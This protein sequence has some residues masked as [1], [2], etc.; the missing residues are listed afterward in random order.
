MSEENAVQKSKKPFLLWAG[1]GVLVTVVVLAALLFKMPAVLT[2]EGAEAL[3]QKLNLLKLGV[4]ISFF[5][6][7]LGEP[8]IKENKTIKVVNYTV[9]WQAPP[10]KKVRD[11]PYTEYFYSN[12]HFYVQAVANSAGIVQF[13]S[14]TAR[15]EK[16]QPKLT[17]G[18][19]EYVELGKTVYESLPK[20]PFK[21][22]GRLAGG[23]KNTAYYEVFAIESK[24]QKLEVFS[25]NPHGILNGLVPLDEKKEGFMTSKYTEETPFPVT[26]VHDT[27]R[28]TTVI[29]TYSAATSEFEGIDTSATGMNYGETKFT[30]GPTDEQIQKLQ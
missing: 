10:Q 13:Y 20:L 25:S 24:V 4:N 29:N 21:F 17:T 6:Q 22:A 5:N 7:H 8:K 30:F 11:V 2:T 14:I 3:T 18:L 23:P 16:F 27:F 1:L 9:D 28:K 19:T 12:P 26:P 15:G